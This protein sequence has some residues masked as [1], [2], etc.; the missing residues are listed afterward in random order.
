MTT[1]SLLVLPALFA[2]AC[3]DPTYPELPETPDTPVE[4]TQVAR[5]GDAP[6]VIATH[7]VQGFE[8]ADPTSIGIDG[9]ASDGYRVEPDGNVWPN[10]SKQLYWV[11]A[12]Q[13]GVGTFEIITNQ[14]IA[15]GLVESAD[16]A[17]VAL[18][19][20]DYQLDGASP[21]A[22]DTNRLGVQVILTDRDGRRL[23]DA[24]LGI[25]GE[26]TAWDHA[27]RPAI[28]GRHLVRAYADSFAER[29]LT[30][31]VVDQIERVESRVTGNQT[32]FHAYS[33][34]TEIATTL[35]ISGG[36]PVAGAS[37]CVI[38]APTDVIAVRR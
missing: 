3:V 7:G 14:G 23:V 11:R 32:C 22:I 29:E 13:A 15:S 16:V 17:N 5:A 12:Q 36:T 34:T 20:A 30:I 25:S 33:G 1:K 38:D 31:E 24:S 35:A 37:N 4:T 28:V 18:V 8:I 9:L 6:V 26:Q 21:F 19:P 10:M 2:A 27:N